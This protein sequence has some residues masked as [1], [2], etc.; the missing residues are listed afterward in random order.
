M[1]S[2]YSFLPRCPA[3]IVTRNV[4]NMD[5]GPSEPSNPTSHGEAAGREKTTSL[6][7]SLPVVCR[8]GQRMCLSTHLVDTTRHGGPLRSCCC[9]W[10]TISAIVDV[11]ADGKANLSRTRYLGE[12]GRESFH[13]AVVRIEYSMNPDRQAETSASD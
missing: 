7:Q 10:C 1:R 5:L 11:P 12:V 9:K 4:G 6:D 13:I 8:Y 2:T 3:M